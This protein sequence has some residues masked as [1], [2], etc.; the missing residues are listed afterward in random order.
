MCE[1]IYPAKKKKRNTRLAAFFVG[2]KMFKY[3][4]YLYG[5]KACSNSFLMMA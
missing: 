5:L 2:K 1:I 3:M 4:Q